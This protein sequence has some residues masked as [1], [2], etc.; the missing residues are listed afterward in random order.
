[1]RKISETEISK[2]CEKRVY[3]VKKMACITQNVK[4]WMIGV[5]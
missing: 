4:W 5:G 1:M 2:L 3:M